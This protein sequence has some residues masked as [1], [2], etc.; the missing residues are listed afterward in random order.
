MTVYTKTPRTPEEKRS[1]RPTG[2]LVQ[3][4]LDTK[5]S[6]QLLKMVVGLVQQ[7]DD[8]D[9]PSNLSDSKS[10]SQVE[11]TATACDHDGAALEGDQVMDSS[12]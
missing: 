12:R 1:V 3:L 8:G 5:L 11:T 2:K 7:V 6:L 4:D 10:K 9:I